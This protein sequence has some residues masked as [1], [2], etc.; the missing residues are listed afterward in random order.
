[1]L[2]QVVFNDP[3]GFGAHAM[4]F[5][6]FRARDT[7]ELSQ[8]LLH[9]GG[10]G[11]CGQASRNRASALPEAILVGSVGYG[12]ASKNCSIAVASGRWKG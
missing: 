5:R 12:M 3:K 9:M 6:K 1:V 7:R 4:E 10:R 8:A 2:G 11:V